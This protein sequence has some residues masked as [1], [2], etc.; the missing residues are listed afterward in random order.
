MAVRI[1]GHH[2]DIHE[3]FRSYI[4]SKLP[5]LE[6]YTD[7]IQHLEI[8]LE[9]DGPNTLAELR[10]KAGPLDVNVKHRDPDPTKA[11]DLLIDKAERAINK[12]HDMI[13]GRKK[14]VTAI[15]QIAKKADFSPDSEPAPLIEPGPHL[16]NGNGHDRQAGNRAV[17]VIHEKLNV[18]IFPSPKNPSG[19]MTVQEAAEELFFRDENFLCFTNADN[20]EFSIIYRRKDGNFALMQANGAA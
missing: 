16:T 14:R 10:F 8:V 7:H 9:E 1:Y 12:K 19:P 6:K 4:E 5:R 3:T 13:Q 15:N 20:D 2:V 17:P 18:R 11:V